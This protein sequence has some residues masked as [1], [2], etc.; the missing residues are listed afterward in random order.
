MHRRPLHLIDEGVDVLERRCIAGAEISA[1]RHPR[2]VAEQRF[3]DLNGLQFVIQ[4]TRRIPPDRDRRHPDTA[5]PDSVNLDSVSSRRLRG[6]ERVHQAAIVHTV[7]END[8]YPRSPGC[9][10]KPVGS[11]RDCRPNRGTVLELAGL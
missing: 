1:A 5:Y 6:G 9:I 3:I 7:G 10:S 8:H 2:N 4:A 11:R